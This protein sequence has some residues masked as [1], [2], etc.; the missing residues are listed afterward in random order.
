LPEA[1]M[2]TINGA[3]VRC[4][5]LVEGDALQIGT[6]VFIYHNRFATA[7]DAMLESAGV[8]T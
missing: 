5:T 6:R 2:V 7:R 1:P 3:R 4:R 8:N